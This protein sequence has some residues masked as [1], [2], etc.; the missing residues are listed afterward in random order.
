MTPM[1]VN[2]ST[3]LSAE[4][5]E[6]PLSEREMDVARLLVTGAS[7]TEIAR[8]LTISP[9]TVKVHLRNV[10]EKLQVNSRTEASTL[11]LQRGWV[12]LPG[13]EA[14]TTAT[15]TAVATALPTVEPLPPLP[16]QASNWQLVYMLAA[17]LVCIVAFF[18]PSFMGRTQ[19]KI[20]LLTDASSATLGRTLVEMIPRW[21][22]LA[23][24]LTPRSRQATALLGSS[25]YIIGGES[26]EGQLLADVERYQLKLD[27]WQSMPPLPRAL[28]NTS[29][30]GL[31]QHIY[32][33]GG[34][35]VDA[36]T[37]TPQLSDQLLVYSAVD[38]AWTAQGNLPYPLV[39]AALTSDDNS[40]Y[41]VGGWDGEKAHDEI[42]RYTPAPDNATM[43]VAWEPVGRAP[44]ARAFLGATVLK[45]KLYVVGGF[46][47]QSE[48]ANADVLDL[49]SGEWQ[50]LP[51]LSVPRG[52]LSLVADDVAIYAVGGGW[53]GAIDT[54]ERYDPDIGLWS[55]FASSIRGEWRNLGAVAIDGSLHLLGGWSGEYLDTHLRYESS[56]RWLLLPLI[57]N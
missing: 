20:D 13:M 21:E 9:Q 26:A 6:N 33:A 39:G 34:S 24:M 8:G 45:G 35:Y 49:T 10:F 36:A 19:P 55:N 44:E 4:P 28:S 52:G 29:A 14:E 17:I 2:E 42:W 37:N 5:T 48:M 11:L 54:H 16:A 25:I 38:Q 41:L 56:I 18:A 15:L 30:V 32:V 31:N 12:V 3:I 27:L 22:A 40:I 57:R 53:T 51:D 50:K 7:N 1:A 23:P 43:S 46:D 47:G